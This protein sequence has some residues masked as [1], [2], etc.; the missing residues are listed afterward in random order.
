VAFGFA[1]HIRFA[2]RQSEQHYLFRSLEFSFNYFMSHEQQVEGLQ[3]QEVPAFFV[4]DALQRCPCVGAAS[5]PPSAAS[6]AHAADVCHTRPPDQ[7]WYDFFRLHIVR[8]A[9]LP[10]PC[11]CS[12]GESARK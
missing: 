4:G 12:H 2:N 10:Q 5:L 8:L 6:H 1:Y 7:I 11:H 9:A 3:N